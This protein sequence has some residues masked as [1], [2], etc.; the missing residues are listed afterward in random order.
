MK[1]VFMSLAVVSLM[2]AAVACGNNSKK[3]ETTDTTAVETAAD[4]TAVADTTAADTTVVA[5]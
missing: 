3:A 2:V 5:Q 1:K 4:T